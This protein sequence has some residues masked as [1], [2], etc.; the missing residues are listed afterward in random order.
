MSGYRETRDLTGSDKQGK[1]LETSAQESAKVFMQSS[2]TA[3][4][5]HALTLIPLNILGDSPVPTGLYGLP[6]CQEQARADQR[7]P[8][9][10]R[11]GKDKGVQD[12]GRVNK[13]LN[14]NRQLA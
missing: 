8:E 11:L 13:K 3:K 5:P 12:D 1:N 7:S 2:T 9:N 14:L 6:D 10:E 4:S